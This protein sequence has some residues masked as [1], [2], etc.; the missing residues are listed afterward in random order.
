MKLR[1]LSMLACLYFVCLGNP[2]VFGQVLKMGKAGKGAVLSIRKLDTERF[3]RKVF[4]NLKNNNLSDFKEIT[5]KTNPRR[6]KKKDLESIKFINQMGELTVDM[7]NGE[8]MMTYL[9]KPLQDKQ[10]YIIKLTVKLNG[11][12]LIIPP[13]MLN[14]EPGKLFLFGLTEK[15][16]HLVGNLELIVTQEKWGEYILPYGVTC[17]VMPTFTAKQKV[18]HWIGFG[19]GAA[20]ISAGR[21]LRTESNDI[22][23]HQ[24]SKAATKDISTPFYTEANK[25]RKQYLA[26]TYFGG[27]LIVADAILLIVRQNRYKKRFEIFNKFCG[28]EGLSLQ[29]TVDFSAPGTASTQ[30]G[31]SMQLTF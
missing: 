18:P 8:I 21:F 12:P 26:L 29:P 24:Y 6:N 30:V 25:K 14:Q 13:E 11:K 16:T 5:S 15:Y 22:Y 23:D 27:G 1:Y 19:V 3:Y 9:S 20:A 31:V 10:Y 28:Q 2:L 17:E 7:Q 4:L